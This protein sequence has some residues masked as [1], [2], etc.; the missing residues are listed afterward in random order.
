MLGSA[1]GIGGVLFYSL[2]IHYYEQEQK[3]LHP[4]SKPK[5]P[6]AVIALMEWQSQYTSE[7]PTAQEYK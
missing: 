6:S 3:K 2:T 4:Q 5:Q 1:V 7:L